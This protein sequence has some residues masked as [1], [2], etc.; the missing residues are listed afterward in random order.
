MKKLDAQI[1]YIPPTT[2]KSGSGQSPSS[3][4]GIS[5][6]SPSPLL[7]AGW[8]TPPLSDLNT[9]KDTT[10]QISREQQNTTQK[11]FQ[12]WKKRHYGKRLTT[13]VKSIGRGAAEDL[14]VTIPND[15]SYWGMTA[16][17][18][19]EVCENDSSGL[20]CHE[21]HLE[22]FHTKNPWGVDSGE[23]GGRRV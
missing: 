22:A 23:R 5:A 6:W 14:T 20:F 4:F 9:K 3:E 10:A 8:V 18:G 19:G 7:T 12:Q 2:T 1:S 21:N 16:K 15:N 13:A 11:E 17:P